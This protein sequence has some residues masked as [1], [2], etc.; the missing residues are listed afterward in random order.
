MQAKAA[1]A[2]R[3]L[4]ATLVL[5][6]HRLLGPVRALSSHVPAVRGLD[7]ARVTRLDPKRRAVVPAAPRSA[8]SDKDESGADVRALERKERLAP[9]G[10]KAA[11]VRTGAAASPTATS[12]DHLLA[13]QAQ[14]QAAVRAQVAQE[15]K[16]LLPKGFK[17]WEE[18]VSF[19]DRHRQR[20]V[21][22][23]QEVQAKLDERVLRQALRPA[24][25]GLKLVRNPD[26]V[27]DLLRDAP[28]A[29]LDKAKRITK[30]RARV[31]ERLRDVLGALLA[32]RALADPALFPAGLPL[33]ICEVDVSRDLRR[34]H[35]RWQLPLPVRLRRLAEPVLGRSVFDTAAADLDPELA[36][37][38]RAREAARR[39]RLL[40]E[41]S[42]MLREA[43]LR[44][45]SLRRRPRD[46]D[47]DGDR[48]FRAAL[49]PTDD[50][51]A[52]IRFDLE[53]PSAAPASARRR[54]RDAHSDVDEHEGDDNRDDRDDVDVAALLKA[55]GP[56][57]RLDDLV[58]NDDLDNDSGL[59]SSVGVNGGT[60]QDRGDPGRREG[61]KESAEDDGD[62]GDDLGVRSVVRRTRPTLR[63]L[64]DAEETSVAPADPA[65]AALEAAAAEALERNAGEL[66]RQLHGQLPMRMVPELV[67][68]R[69]VGSPEDV[70]V[71]ARTRR[72]TLKESAHDRR[73]R[74]AD[75]APTDDTASDADR[76]VDSGRG[77]GDTGREA[78][79][80]STSRPRA[81]VELDD[82]GDAFVK[83][84]RA[85][86][87]KGSRGARSARLGFGDDHAAS[88][89]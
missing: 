54:N 87:R 22:S 42:D 51:V 81:A 63:R 45:R 68:H 39:E 15:R 26:E 85:R 70:V 82:L 79:G 69:F 13:V 71:R 36:A 8:A 61:L 55:L 64:M 38:H 56:D 12:L 10:S 86:A 53:G 24:L 78:I 46:H 74:A 35:V 72:A 57:G 52:G 88:E 1:R 2:P 47:E 27:D 7:G 19:H 77:A 31:N 28:R 48:A 40:W 83:N 11:L 30:R 3:A 34:A 76:A 84:L 29:L 37:D 9:D 44:E 58:D 25:P 32:R 50:A 6:P 66:R 49:S 43:R 23:A 41:R 33:E 14:A 21:R 62:D 73:L 89:R 75:P 65:M 5:A 67:F 60:S 20:R 17:S 80:A 4:A 18:V 16:A 59:G